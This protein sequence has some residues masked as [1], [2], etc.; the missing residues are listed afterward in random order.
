M[1]YVLESLVYIKK[2]KLLFAREHYNMVAIVKIHMN[3]MARLLE[4][5]VGTY[6]EEGSVT[7][8]GR[9]GGGQPIGLLSVILVW[10][11]HSQWLKNA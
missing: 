4:G 7:A 9:C 8:G 1:P 11:V 5:N 6:T 2:L 3:G 10:T